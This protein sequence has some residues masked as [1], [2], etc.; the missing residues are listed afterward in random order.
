VSAGLLGR[1]RRRALGVPA[2]MQEA[3]ILAHLAELLNARQGSSQLDPDY[4]LPDLTDLAH[5]IPE[6]LPVLQRLLSETIRRQEPRL[7]NVSVRHAP[8]SADRLVLQFDVRAELVAGGSLH[9]RTDVSPTGRVR[10]S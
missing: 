3:S 8:G 4:G 5:R 10:I 1:L 7:C 9:F 6:G 2:V